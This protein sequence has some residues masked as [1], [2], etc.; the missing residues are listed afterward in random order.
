MEP[1]HHHKITVTP[2]MVDAGRATVSLPIEH[3]DDRADLAVKFSEHAGNKLAING[4]KPRTLERYIKGNLNLVVRRTNPGG[5][6]YGIIFQA[7]PNGRKIQRGGGA[8]SGHNHDAGVQPHGDQPPVF[9]LDVQLMHGEQ[10]I[11]PSFVWVE[12]FDRYSVLFGKPV[13]FFD[14]PVHRV[15]KFLRVPPDREI[16]VSWREGAVSLGKRDSEQI[17]AASQT[18]NDKPD[19]DVDDWIERFNIREFNMRFP[20]FRVVFLDETVRAI[21]SPGVDSADELWDL[22][23]GPVNA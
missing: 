19:F 7:R 1:K 22:G 14:S 15:N 4:G 11:I 6:D 17:K 10:K 16:N 3:F 18:V 20:K 13:Y 2:A 5:C 12:V 23:F 8:F 9:S 21:V